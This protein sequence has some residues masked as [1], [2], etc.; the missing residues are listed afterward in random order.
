[1]ARTDVYI[2]GGLKDYYHY[3][4]QDKLLESAIAYFCGDIDPEYPNTLPQ[5][6]ATMDIT[7]VTLFSQSRAAMAINGGGEEEGGEG[8]ESPPGKWV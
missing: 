2:N 3:Y 1:M 4:F 6:G 5:Y 8:E 7:Q